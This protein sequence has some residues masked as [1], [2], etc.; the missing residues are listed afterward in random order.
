MKVNTRP[1][2]DRAEKKPRTVQKHEYSRV[3]LQFSTSGT[4]E[5]FKK[6]DS[7]NFFLLPQF[8]LGRRQLEFPNFL[9]CQWSELF[10]PI[11]TQAISVATTTIVKRKKCTSMYN[12]IS[13]AAAW[14]LAS[15]LQQQQQF[16]YCMN[17]YRVEQLTTLTT[18]LAGFFSTMIKE[19]QQ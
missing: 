15:R 13:T 6:V 3:L 16:Q 18:T 1:K 9:Q 7:R 2:S 4:V 5:C 17:I 8:S 14:L 10:H 19:H 11:F 12:C